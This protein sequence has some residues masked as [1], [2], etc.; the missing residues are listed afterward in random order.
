MDFASAATITLIGMS[1]SD[2]KLANAA[3]SGNIIVHAGGGNSLVINA[4]D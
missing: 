3:E 4:M 2:L 1:L